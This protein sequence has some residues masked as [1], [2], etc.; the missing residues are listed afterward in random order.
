MTVVELQNQ[1]N[2]ERRF[3]N[4]T[5]P[6]ILVWAGQV[7][8]LIF[9]AYVGL[10]TCLSPPESKYLIIFR[11]SVLILGLI[12]PIMVARR[13]IKGSKPVI[14]VESWFPIRFY[15]YILFLTL[16]IITLT[17]HFQAF[18]QPDEMRSFTTSL[19]VLN[20]GLGAGAV[21]LWPGLCSARP[22][23]FWQVLDV[24]GL[25][26][27]LILALL[28]IGLN[29]YMAF[30]TSPLFWFDSSAGAN[31]TRYKAAPG[32][33]HLDF[34]FN[35]NGYYDSDFFVA[36][37]NDLVICLLADSFG[38]GVVPNKYNFTSVAEKKLAQTCSQAYDRVAIHNFG[39]VNIGLLEY[40][41]LLKTE[42]KTYKP[43]MVVVCA[44]VGND[45]S[46]RRPKQITDY[47]VGQNWVLWNIAAR[48]YSLS[49]E[50]RPIVGNWHTS[51]GLATDHRYLFDSSLESPH[52]SEKNY[53]K[54]EL[55]RMKICK[56]DSY[57]LN[58]MYKDFFNVLSSIKKEAGDKLLLV[59]IPD[60]FQVN[61]GLYKSMMT[62]VNPQSYDR[63]LPQN[64]IG[65]FC[66]ENNIE[67]LDLLPILRQAE[68][69]DHTYHLR[70]SHWNRR[71]NEVAGLA[72]ADYLASKYCGSNQSPQNQ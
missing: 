20:M 24:T 12:P 45:L 59:V 51:E 13:I 50:P 71:G 4:L 16:I 32:S 48:L 62:Q 56:K 57:T 2:D 3:V 63:F 31:I 54:M 61:D 64:R 21:L 6:T 35:K 46:V 60:E 65:K 34:E 15:F 19:L 67:M 26:V 43:K 66:R 29:I 14:R 69:D 37:P 70:D 18:P 47:F 9:Y 27:V 22:K 39:I 38:V 8:F 42:V 5:V 55:Y 53:M 52:F 49:G 41:H 58:G 11:L 7:V 1:G 36:G 33:S 28:E 40:L 10:E 44:F 23:G 17:Q 25:N 72:I 68:K 30:S